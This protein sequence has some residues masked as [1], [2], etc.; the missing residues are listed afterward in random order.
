MGFRVGRLA[1]SGILFRIACMSSQLSSAAFAPVVL[2]G[3]VTGGIGSALARQLVAAG[4]SV[5]GYGRSVEKLA[6]L[7][8]ELPSLFTLTVEATQP[9]D[10]EAAVAATVAHFG[11]LDAYVHTVG[12]ILIKPAHQTRPEEWLRVLDLNLNSA[13]YG[14][15]AALG[16]MQAQNSGSI[17]LVSSV[18]AQAGLPAHEAIA[19]AKGGIDGL[20][21]AA[22]ASYAP[23]N[24]R[25]NAVAPG[26]V[27]TPLAAP[28]LASEQART[29]SEKMH[30]LGRIGRPE[31][32]ASLIAWL[33]TPDADWVTGQIYSI[34]GG[35][36]HLRPRPKV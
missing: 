23:R 34:D 26:L 20:V 22:A 3:G 27:D 18:A 13:F 35:L 29:F 24:I 4:A 21:R 36:A 33:L 9:A 15:R 7:Q 6:A 25:V 8:A 17:V 1:F 32:V 10:V 2:I 30:P 16:P 31:Q 19:A 12:S 5:A 11:R 28:L 14:L